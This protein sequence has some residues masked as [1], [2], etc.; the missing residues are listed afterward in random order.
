VSRRAEVFSKKQA[1]EGAGRRS[2]GGGAEGPR[3]LTDNFVDP[4]M[5]T[6]ETS[7]WSAR[8]AIG[9]GPVLSTIG[10]D[11]MRLAAALALSALLASTAARA[12]T[13]DEL[14]KLATAD[15]A[16][17]LEQISAIV[18]RGDAAD[19]PALRA[20]L[21]GKLWALGDQVFIGEGALP[22]PAEAEKVSINNRVRRSLERGLDA[23]GLFAKNPQ[24]RL[25]AARALQE[26]GDADLSPLV[27]RALAGE[28]DAQVKE[29]LLS[30]QGALLLASP[31]TPERLAAIEVLQR[32]P[33]TR[34]RRLLVERLDS[35]RDEKLRAT[36][37]AG[38]QRI[39][40][41]LARAE[42]VGWI[43]GG[44][45]LGSVLLLAALGLSITFG[46]MGVINMAH[47]EL[48]MIGAYATYV[49]QTMFRA[50]FPGAF[51]L[52]LLAAAP[53]A[54]LAAGLAGML[55][56]I[57]V[58]RPL[59]GR[60][61][62]T[63][64]ATWGASLLFIQIV[65]GLFGAQNVEVANPSWMSGG[66][67]ALPGLVLP[68]N[69]MAIIAFALAVLCIVWLLLERTRLGLLVRAVMQNRGMAGGLGV[70]TPWI[71]RLAFSLGAGIA[72]L[73]GCALSQ[74]GNVGPELGQG[75]I[76]DSFMVV[77][78][79]G[80]GQL[81]GTVIAAAGLGQVNKLLEP[82]AGAVLAKIAVLAFIIV[83]IQ[84]RPQGLFAPR[85]RA[86]EEA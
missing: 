81:A 75:F 7:A 49:V 9:D 84:R 38:I 82:Y 78:L 36:L 10:G 1:T 20:L 23:L 77:V 21:E 33:S 37:A 15:A 61:L 67:N 58:V 62:E 60:P 65:R 42:V 41:S 70:A 57:A 12:L 24:Q 74:I 54:F 52:Y 34:N 73:G 45:S 43:F 76:V 35:E 22:V 25:A 50:H 3:P 32:A 59:Y 18:A 86:A 16:E 72:G 68:Y 30:V 69:R 85:G 6:T 17:K 14:R 51:D 55:L 53:I 11:E 56:E 79:G 44:L 13:Q 63:L 71:D 39:D 5:R 48:L 64:L 47:G 83:F 26:S 19:A 31:Q 29:A 40:R 80:V 28:K 8:L 2:L 66:V 4:E 46:L 27:A